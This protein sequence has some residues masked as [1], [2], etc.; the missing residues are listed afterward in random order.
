MAEPPFLTERLLLRPFRDEDLA[1]WLEHFNTAAVRE[2]LAGVQSEDQARASFARMA[3]SWNADGFGFL[4]IERLSDSVLIG[5]CGIGRVLDKPAP[6]PLASGLQLGWQLR[7]EAWG[8]GYATE[9][10]RALLAFAFDTL[11][12][13]TVWAQTSERNRGSW[14]VMQRLGMTRRAECDY[15]DPAYPP[16]DNPAMVWSIDRSAWAAEHG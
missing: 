14:S 11:A 2:Y 8:Q 9:A 4:A 6:E 3:A 12:L 1:V 10:A 7:P 13:E 5:T 15:S 16:Q